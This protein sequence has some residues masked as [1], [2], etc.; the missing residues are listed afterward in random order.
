MRKLYMAIAAFAALLFSQIGHAIPTIPGATDV[1]TNDGETYYALMEQG[2]GWVIAGY[3]AN[4]VATGFVTQLTANG[5]NISNAKARYVGLA[6]DGTSFMAMRNDNISAVN[7]DSYSVLSFDF[8]GQKTGV[9]QLVNGSGANILA[10]QV[11]YT[12]LS[13]AEE[14]MFALRNDLISPKGTDSWSLINFDMA[15]QLNKAGNR[16]GVDGVLASSIDYNAVASF[17]QSPAVFQLK[18]N[19]EA[20]VPEP[21]TALLLG[22][23]LGLGAMRRKLTKAAA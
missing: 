12:G 15:G 21:A 22:S 7:R 18:S 4:G 13:V 20:S 19:P 3:D 10:S 16:V 5:N 8:A 2:S 17:N 14:G 9:T 6:F 1:A 23:L 11:V